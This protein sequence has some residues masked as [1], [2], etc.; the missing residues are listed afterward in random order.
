M[1]DIEEYTEFLDFM[2]GDI[3]VM[4]DDRPESIQKIDSFYNKIAEVTKRAELIL[5]ED[6]LSYETALR[7]NVLAKEISKDLDIERKRLIEEPRKF[8]AMI[9]DRARQL[10]ETLTLVD[11]ILK[12]KIIEWQATEE[13]KSRESKAAVQRLSETMGFDISSP[14]SGFTSS[15]ASTYTKEKQTFEIT[16]SDLVPDMYW[17]ID[18]KAIQRHIDL[19]KT[20]IPGVKLVTHKTFH[21]RKK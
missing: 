10:Q 4:Q 11:G 12:I 16:D 21:I 20:D 2:K 17:V 13:S 19:G 5:I 1:I 8:I 7:L 18:E 9:N 6:G 3:V 14:S 15:A